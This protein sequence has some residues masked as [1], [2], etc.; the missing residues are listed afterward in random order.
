[1]ADISTERHSG[2]LHISYVESEYRC[3][4]IHNIKADSDNLH[5]KNLIVC[6]QFSIDWP[7]IKNE[8]NRERRDKWWWE[9][10]FAPNL[11]NFVK[12]VRTNGSI[13]YH[14]VYDH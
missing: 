8:E 9:E 7:Q 2:L 1:M 12:V 6:D 11:G 14:K 4:Q 10:M 5:N 3:I 13:E